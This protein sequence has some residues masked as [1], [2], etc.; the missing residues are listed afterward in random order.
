MESKPIR[1]AFGYKMGSGKDTSADY[2]IQKYGGDKISFAKPLYDI[3][4]YAQK[5]AGFP[6]ENDRMFLQWIGNEWGRGKNLDVWA[7]AGMRNLT[8]GNVVLSDLRYINEFYACKKNG[9]LCVKIN[10][11]V[12]DNRKGTGA[13]TH[14]SETELDSI[15]DEEWDY[16]IENNGTKDDLFNDLE[17][18][19][20]IVR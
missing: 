9:I 1:I 11:I 12:S 8:D 5:I 3:L 4:K 15:P 19:V 14:I 13:V 16:I 2:L 20:E 6:L 7:D 10:R 17:K 18:I